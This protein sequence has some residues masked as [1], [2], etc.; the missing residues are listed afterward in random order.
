MTTDERLAAM[1]RENT[2]RHFLDSGG[3]YG[4]H[5]ERN[6]GAE[7][8]ARPAS[9]YEAREYDGKLDLSVT[10]DVYH[11]L[12]ERLD[13]S[14][15]LDA[16]LQRFLERPRAADAYLPD[17]RA[18]AEYLVAHDRRKGD[19]AGGIYHEGDPLTVN[20]YNGED[21]L[22]QTLQYV[23]CDTTSYGEV[24]ILQ[25]HGGCDVRGGYTAPR[26]FV[27][28]GMSELAILDNARGAMYC[29]RD[30]DHYWTTD[31]GCNWYDQGSCGQS[32]T[33]LEDYPTIARDDPSE[34]V[35]IPDPD[36]HQLTFDLEAPRVASSLGYVQVCNHVAYCPTCGG[37]LEASAY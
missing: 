37:R 19:R 8:D 9:T 32:Y 17:M 3:A 13:Y 6:Q 34:V 33:N 20:T 11:W 24:V 2:G 21:L 7:F 4:R 30:A 15:T 5:W 36:P 26:V 29:T 10:H 35:T 31:D 23:Y 22:S 18:F 27:G 16:K 14:E 1:L 28:S 12:R 25:V